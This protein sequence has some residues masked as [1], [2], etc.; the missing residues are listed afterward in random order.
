MHP[1]TKLIIS[2]LGCAGSATLIMVH[3]LFLFPTIGCA[4]LLFCLANYH[5]STSQ[6]DALTGLPNLHHLQQQEPHYRKCDSLTVAYIDLDA[7]KQI[8]DTQG[9]PVGNAALQQVA[10]SL[11]GLCQGG[12]GAY[13]IGGDE[14]LLISETASP[15]QLAQR[16][17]A[18]NWNRISVSYGI[19]QGRG[20]SLQHIIH[21]AEQQMYTKKAKNEAITRP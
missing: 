13:R 21:T 2:L 17:S 4:V 5:L 12:E 16:L 19:A 10:A 1:K 18:V 15:A 20:T 6:T 3:P 9:H 11:S 8:N 7:L 14:F